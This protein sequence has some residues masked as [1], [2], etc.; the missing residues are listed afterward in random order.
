MMTLHSLIFTTDIEDGRVLLGER[1]GRYSN[2][3]PAAP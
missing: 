2:S 3:R 1:T